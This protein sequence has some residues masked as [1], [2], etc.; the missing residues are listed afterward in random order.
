MEPR[1]TLILTFRGSYGESYSQAVEISP[2]IA[3]EIARIRVPSPFDFHPNRSALEQTIEV[4]RMK[5]LRKDL[6]TDEATHLGILLAERMEDKEGWHGMDRADH[7]KE[8]GK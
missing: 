3:T 8:W 7:L 1:W 4:L 2:D 5:Q 6:F